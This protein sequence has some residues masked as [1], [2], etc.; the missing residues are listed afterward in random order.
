LY[1]LEDPDE[2]TVA[3]YIGTRSRAFFAVMH[4]HGL[5]VIVDKQSAE[6]RSP[7]SESLLR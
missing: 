7:I 6:T 5:V 1:F 3:A 4:D 2:P